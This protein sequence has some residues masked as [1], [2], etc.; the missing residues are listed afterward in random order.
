MLDKVID[1]N[2]RLGS[3]YLVRGKALYLI[4]TC[5]FS[6]FISMLR[7]AVNPEEVAAQGQLLF[8]AS[9][10]PLQVWQAFGGGHAEWALRHLLQ[11][12][13]S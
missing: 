3:N 10:S 11:A 7:M 8:G 1:P 5:T 6:P 2:A 4:Q 9:A 13:R 12:K